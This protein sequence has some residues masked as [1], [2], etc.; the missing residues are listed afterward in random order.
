MLKM[1]YLIFITILFCFSAK[2]V[3][4]IE[5]KLIA[6]IFEKS[7]LHNKTLV[8]GSFHEYAKKN[9][10]DITITL[11]LLKYDKP[12]DSFTYFKSFV[13]SLLKNKNTSAY[14]IYFY[15]A[16]FI[17]I[18]GPYLLK[19]NSKLPEELIEMYNPRV[20]EEE[21]TYKNE[22]V[23]FPLSITYEVMYSNKNLLSKYA[24][25]IPKTWNELIETCKYIMER[26]NDSELICYNGF[27]D[28][29][30]QGLYS[31]YEFIY[32]C[33]DS[34]NS[35]YPNP[36]DKSFIESLKM[37][38]R[39]KDEVA[40]DT[41]FK[42]NENF[43]FSK[44]LSGKAIFIKYWLVGEP[45]LSSLQY[46]LSVLPGLNEGVSGSMAEG[47]NMGISKYLPE[48]KIEAALEVIKF[49]TSKE[50]QRGILENLGFPT[51]LTELL[52]DEE[53][54]KKAKCN[55]LNE[56]Q[57]TGEPLFIRDGPDDFR[58]KYKKYIYQ[59]LYDNKT[60][61]ETLKKIVDLSKIYYVSLDME[62]TS[63]GLIYFI[64][65]SVVTILMLLS[66]VILFNDK[67]NKFFIYLP[68]DFWIINVLGS[69]LILWIPLFS[70][71]QIKPI[72]CHLKTLLLSVGY[73]LNLGT[74]LCKL[75]SQYPKK[76]KISDWVNNHRY[77]FLL[78]NILIDILINSISFINPYSVK[79]IGIDEGEK[80]EIC[81]FKG[82]VG[83][84]ILTVYKSAILL[85][86]L[87]FV[88]IEW[89]I[90]EIKYP[91]LIP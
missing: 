45:L 81:N 83:I 33:R 7:S 13:E 61:D 74:I 54:C 46:H 2:I 88:F 49:L 73:T 14:D 27:F 69:I 6:P 67:F 91:L 28:D 48:K 87:L 56:I 64:F 89:N 60:V 22:L 37:L 23:G 29:T 72:N 15:N 58:K 82:E 78:L 53:V 44:L 90:S 57:F 11:D 51:A 38:K 34:Y 84:I 30:E 65:I 12:T 10:L 20:L 40:S 32:S 1:L 5:I 3:D 47:D 36:G 21:C 9:N 50:Y 4:A 68:T 59:Y 77:M 41:I 26:E 76:N 62:N 63:V 86:L 18:Y 35:T 70:Y 66:L 52:N 85:T 42:S 55:L 19:L 39:I 25:P 17:S 80:F 31:L 43:T 8:E 75:I 24:K 16:K 71:G 79:Q